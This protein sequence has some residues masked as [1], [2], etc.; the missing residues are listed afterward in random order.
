MLMVTAEQVR[1]HRLFQATKTE[2]LTGFHLDRNFWSSFD[3]RDPEL[4]L[5]LAAVKGSVPSRTNAVYQTSKQIALPRTPFMGRQQPIFRRTWSNT[6]PA[7]LAP[8]C[9]PSW[10]KQSTWD[11]LP[12]DLHNGKG[13]SW[14]AHAWAACRRPVPRANASP[15]SCVR[16]TEATALFEG[17]RAVADLS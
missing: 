8:T 9:S 5:L 10:T 17:I 4:G 3:H 11:M 14:M 1:D 15:S 7:S 6:G 13:G 12:E 2:L 16:P